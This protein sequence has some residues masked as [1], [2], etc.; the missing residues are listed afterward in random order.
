MLLDVHVNL[1]LLRS[2][3]PN[4]VCVYV[5]VCACVRVLCVWAETE[6]LCGDGV[7]NKKKDKE[8]RWMMGG[9]QRWGGGRGGGISVRG[10]EA[11]AWLRLAATDTVQVVDGSVEGELHS[12]SE[13]GGARLRQLDSVE[14]LDPER[15]HL[16]SRKP[17]PA[18]LA[19]EEVDEEEFLCGPV[20]HP[21]SGFENVQRRPGKLH[22][23]VLIPHP[24]HSGVHDLKRSWRLW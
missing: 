10:G 2:E 8:E 5:C 23:V 24:P 4:M 16:R 15:S 7:Q 20:L 12:F 22:P 11:G 1:E 18:A 14:R 21:L 19:V 6:R 17:L 13:A 9:F 3:E